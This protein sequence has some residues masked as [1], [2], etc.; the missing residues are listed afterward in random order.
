MNNSDYL[1][2][3]NGLQV[4]VGLI[5][6]QGLEQEFAHQIV[7]ERQKNG[8]YKNLNDIL[9]RLHPA[10][11]QLNI[12]IRIGA[13]RF[14]GLDKKTL[15]WE[16]NFRNK[17]TEKDDP[18]T[19]FETEEVKFSLPEFEK[20][21][22]EDLRDELDL[23]GFVVGDFYELLNKEH[24][25]GSILV[26]QLPNLLGQQIKVIGR[27]VTLKETRTIKNERMCFGTFLDVEG[28]WLDTVHFPPVLRQYPFQGSG[29]Y[30]L[31]GR[32][33]E[34]FG[35]YSVEV[36]AMRKLGYNL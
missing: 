5:H 33:M 35:V 8:P 1:T 2:N 20:N 16:A 22:M 15:L 13:L 24:L 6:L 21:R 25:N 11:E 31:H 26:K 10:P 7:E 19:L 3:I 29:F 28:E 30:E 14:T 34:E 32:V 18:I 23:L 27:M 4:Y 12:L 17:R 9:Q 36:T